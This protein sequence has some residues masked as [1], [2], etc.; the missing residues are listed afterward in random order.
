MRLLL[1]LLLALSL[2]ARAAEPVVA[3]WLEKVVL[4][5]T[6][7]EVTAKLDTG[8]KTSS[9]DAEDVEPF[10]RDGE[11]WVRF[12]VRTGK[13]LTGELRRFEA[14]LVGEKVIRGA[15]GR[16]QRML[17]D[18]WLCVAGERRRVLFTLVDRDEMNYRVIL[19]R[20]ALEGRLLVDSARTYLLAPGCEAR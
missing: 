10:D 13:G 2:P 15:L 11:P 19:G 16:Q 12:G 8:A 4:P 3:G 5:D 7:L 20:R 6:G 17:V 9:I 14:R 1:P 18:L